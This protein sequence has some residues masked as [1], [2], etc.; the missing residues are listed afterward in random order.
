M[1]KYAIYQGKIGLWAI[2][3]ADTKEAIKPYGYIK[4][5]YLP[6]IINNMGGYTHFDEEYEMTKGFREIV[7]LDDEDEYPLTREQMFPKNSPDFEYGWID[8]EGNTY[9]TGHEGHSKSALHICEEFG[10]G[11][12]HPERT[13]EEMGWVKVT[14][15]WDCGVLQKDVF[16]SSEKNYFITKS[17]ADTLFDLGLWNNRHVQMYVDRSEKEW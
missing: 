3:Y 4:S 6:V 10:Y 16:A 14:G 1:I 11:A 8:L 15:H 7:V 17:Q 5:E 12:Y 9:N 2:E 13:L